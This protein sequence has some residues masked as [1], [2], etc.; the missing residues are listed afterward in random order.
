MFGVGIFRL[1]S[2]GKFYLIFVREALV[3]LN[4]LLDFDRHMFLLVLVKP[5]PTYPCLVHHQLSLARDITASS[6][7]RTNQLISIAH[8]RLNLSC[9][10][11]SWSAWP[12]SWPGHRWLDTK[13]RAMSAQPQS[14]YCWLNWRSFSPNPSIFPSIMSQLVV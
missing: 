11:Y 12:W 6:S 2:T 4:F 3:G 14:Q 1:V 13:A 5:L 8:L 9:M 7:T 10:V